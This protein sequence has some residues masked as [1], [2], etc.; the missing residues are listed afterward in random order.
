M[1]GSTGYLS[2]FLYSLWQIVSDANIW[3]FKIAA[4]SPHF[5]S[6]V[7]TGEAD[8]NW[9]YSASAMLTKT[10][11]STELELVCLFTVKFDVVGE[12]TTNETCTIF[13]RTFRN[14][15]KSHVPSTVVHLLAD[16]FV[17]IQGLFAFTIWYRFKGVSLVG[18]RELKRAFQLF[19]FCVNCFT[20]SFA[21]AS[22]F[23][24]WEI[25]S[26]RLTASCSMSVIR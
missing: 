18:L 19:G 14:F 4:H 17:V 21:S 20:S 22:W 8:Y 3:A 5:I 23:S 16:E 25:R 9:S 12:N 2:G 15:V 13:V 26:C 6:V 10:M 7:S 1:A 24:S 11:Y